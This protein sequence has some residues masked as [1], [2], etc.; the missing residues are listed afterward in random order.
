MLG[1]FRRQVADFRCCGRRGAQQLSFVTGRHRP[2]LGNR[3]G[4]VPTTSLPRGKRLLSDPAGLLAFGSTH[5]NAFPCLP[6]FIRNG[7][8]TVADCYD[9]PRLQRRDRDGIPIMIGHRLP[10][11][12][13][14]TTCVGKAVRKHLI[15]RMIWNQT[16]WR[17]CIRNH[18]AGKAAVW[19]E[20]ATLLVE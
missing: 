10:F 9:S 6:E 5:R 16:I 2:Q 1:S 8:D 19:K 15:R 13:A 20:L 12:L 3:L 14:P 17:N 7:T 18:R 11:S 4:S